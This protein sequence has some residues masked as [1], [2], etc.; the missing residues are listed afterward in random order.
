[1]KSMLEKDYIKRYN[2]EDIKIHPWISEEFKDDY[3][4]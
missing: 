4:E 2:V 1:M 3:Q